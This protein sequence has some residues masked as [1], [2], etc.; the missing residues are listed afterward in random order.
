MRFNRR[1]FPKSLNPNAARRPAN[2]ERKARVRFSTIIG[3][4]VEKST[5][6][7]SISIGLG[8][9]RE[10][11]RRI[12]PQFFCRSETTHP[13]GNRGRQ[14]TFPFSDTHHFGRSQ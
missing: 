3:A 6:A 10:T 13:N 2:T 12:L 14:I 9:I 11:C 1:T 8:S 4:I 7:I 5:V